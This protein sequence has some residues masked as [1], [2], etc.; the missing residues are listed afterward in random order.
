MG[1]VLSFIFTRASNYGF[2]DM[3]Q[4]QGP[5]PVVFCGVPQKLFNV[6]QVLTTTLRSRASWWHSGHRFNP[7]TNTTA[8]IPHNTQIL[9]LASPLQLTHLSRDVLTRAGPEWTPPTDRD[10]STQN[11][12]Q[13]KNTSTISH[14][15]HLSFSNETKEANLMRSRHLPK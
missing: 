6:S 1:L 12:P 9:P 11:T 13:R 2:K 10:N 8:T 3:V 5:P 4:F 7:P 15:A 14:E